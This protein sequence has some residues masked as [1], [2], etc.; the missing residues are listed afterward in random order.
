MGPEGGQYSIYFKGGDSFNIQHWQVPAVIDTQGYDIVQA[1]E[2]AAVFTKKTMLTNYSG[3]VF[4]IEIN[5]KIK[6]LNS[7]DV[8]AAIKSPVPASLHLVGYE[9]ENNI[10]NTV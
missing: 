1:G 8:S 4:N 3:T 6:L 9:T 10:T 5:R 2:S 7:N